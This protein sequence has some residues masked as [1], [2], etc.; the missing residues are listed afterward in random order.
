MLI[1]LTFLYTFFSTSISLPTVSDLVDNAT[2]PRRLAREA[3]P[4]SVVKST[5]D[6]RRPSPEHTSVPYVVTST[7]YDNRPDLPDLEDDHSEPKENVYYRPASANA[8]PGM[9]F[10]IKNI[11]K[12]KIN[13]KIENL[14]FK[15]DV[16]MNISKCNENVFKMQYNHVCKLDFKISFQ[17]LV[18]QNSNLVV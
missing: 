7:S 15:N 3:T 1:R 14:K 4:P 16:K 11:Q 2:V 6:R 18:H 8:V 10:K 12:F 13:Y 9:F 5:S 17:K